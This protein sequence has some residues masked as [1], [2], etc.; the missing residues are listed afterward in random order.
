MRG[1]HCE[2]ALR[3]DAAIPSKDEIRHFVS[4]NDEI[5]ECSQ[6]PK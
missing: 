6:I 4:R 5:N 3:A 1:C 2:E